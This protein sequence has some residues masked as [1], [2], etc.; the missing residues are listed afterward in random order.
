VRGISYR[1]IVIRSGVIS[2]PNMRKEYQELVT[3]LEPDWVEPPKGLELVTPVVDTVRV[4]EADVEVLEV[5]VVVGVP[6][7]E[8]GVVPGAD[9]EVG[10]V[11]VALSARKLA[12]AAAESPP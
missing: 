7:V 3:G 4:A 10:K 1:P 12:E 9:E 8:T 2:T 5:L 6:M 11:N